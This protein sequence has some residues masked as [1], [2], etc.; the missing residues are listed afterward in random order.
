MRLVSVVVAA[1]VCACGSVEK[2]HS[3]A[4]VDAPPPGDAPMVD[5]PVAPQ[6]AS[7]SP[8]KGIVT[9]AVTISGSRFGAAQ[10][11][12]TIGGAAATVAT[13]SDTSIALTVPDVLPGDAD[14]VV[15]TAAGNSPPATFQVILPPAIYLENDVAGADTF[16]SVSALAF[17][18]GTGAV[19]QIGQPVTMG[20]APSGYGG[21]STSIYAHAHTRHLFAAAGGK[22]AV[23]TI[24]PVTGGITPIT[25]SPFDAGGARSFA[26]MTN[27]AGNRLF[28]ANYDG[29]NVGVFDVAA[30]GTPTPVAG[31]PFTAPFAIDTLA[32]SKDETFL[33]VNSYGASYTGFS[34]ASNGALTALAAQ[35]T[36]GTGIMRRPGT[37]QLLIPSSSN[38]L[39]VW[40]V[41]ADGSVTPITGSPFALN[42]GGTTQTGA[43]TPD[44][45]RVYF[46]PYGTGNIIGYSLAADGTPTALTGSPWSFATSLSSISCVAVSQDSGYLVAVGENQ[47]KV[48]VFTL[49]TAGTPAQVTGSPFTF[50]PASSSASGLAITF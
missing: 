45:G 26:V 30:D 33:Y 15:T 25:G 13:W 23:Y 2:Q 50:L 4:A 24:D 17:D 38:T 41:A 16:D 22:V 1:C 40:S 7:V 47:Q 43:F 8:A 37:D 3:D 14:V 32:L 27:A 49:D 35:N 11:S 19:T 12:V 18:P 29:H 39:G 9:T 28:V 34:V 31:S 44:G 21:C 20:V 42:G 36:G 6:I 10:G 46:G 5:A 48:G